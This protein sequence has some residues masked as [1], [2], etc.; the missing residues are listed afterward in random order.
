MAYR[1]LSDHERSYITRGVQEDIRADGRGC[2]DY[3]HFELCTGVVSNTSGSAEI[4]LERTNITVGVKAEIGNPL[5][6]QPNRGRIEFFVDCS[7]LASPEFQGRE[8]EGLG[9]HLAYRLSEIYQNSRCIDLESLSI[10]PGQQCWILYVD[11]LVLE[12]SGGV[13]DC[14]SIAVKAALGDTKIPKLQV[15][16]EGEEI[17]VE[18]SDNPYDATPVDA[19]NAPIIVTLSLVGGHFVVDASHEEESCA[20][21]QL[22]VAMDTKG[23][24]CGIL[25]EGTGSIPGSQYQKALM[26]TSDV[27]KS[28][29]DRME[30]NIVDS[31]N[32]IL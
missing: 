14:L 16:G 5:P 9:Q 13:L 10:I 21:C 1:T 24:T 4:K 7:A 18:V 8:G 6:L 29:F 30:Q 20:T 2:I 31:D 26:L 27:A 32:M 12:W 25:K 19:S 15:T 23:R 28:V 22:S 3:R 17:E 11:A